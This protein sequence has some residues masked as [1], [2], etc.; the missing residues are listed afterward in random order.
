LTVP[1][2]VCDVLTATASNAKVAKKAKWA[3][4]F[5]GRVGLAIAIEQGVWGRKGERRG[6]DAKEWSLEGREVGRGKGNKKPTPN[7]PPPL[8][9]WP[10]CS[11]DGL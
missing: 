4:H 7:V 5:I 8:Y 2:P 9:I 10:A 11:Q 1:R 3:K 6:K